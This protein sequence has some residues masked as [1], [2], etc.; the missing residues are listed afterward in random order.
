MSYYSNSFISRWLIPTLLGSTQQ[1]SQHMKTSSTDDVPRTFFS[2][3]PSST[4]VAGKASDQP[5]R[6]PVSQEEIEAICWLAA[7][8][9]EAKMC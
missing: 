9:F 8:N 5:K 7:T 3:S 6:T 4:A 1:N 2:R